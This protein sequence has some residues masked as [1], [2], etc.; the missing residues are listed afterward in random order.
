MKFWYKSG[1]LR[2]RI[3][4]LIEF[5]DE[6]L[7]LLDLETGEYIIKHWKEVEYIL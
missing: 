4:R 5:Y 6:Y 2:M 3:G 1:T 7:E